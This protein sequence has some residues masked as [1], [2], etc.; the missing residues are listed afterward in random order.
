MDTSLL[1]YQATLHVIYN[2]PGAEI[3]HILNENQVLQE[4]IEIF[5]D[6]VE[7][8]KIFMVFSQK[9]R[10]VTLKSLILEKAYLETQD[11]KEF[12]NYAE[13]N[14]LPYFNEIRFL[15]SSSPQDLSY[16]IAIKTPESEANI[17]LASC[18]IKVTSATKCLGIFNKTKYEK[19]GHLHNNDV[20]DYIETYLLIK[21][22][23][24]PVLRLVSSYQLHELIGEK[25]TGRGIKTNSKKTHK[26]FEDNMGKA[27]LEIELLA[28]AT[29]NL[30][31][32]GQAQR[33]DTI[34][35][36][37]KVLGSLPPGK[38]HRFD[39]NNKKHMKLVQESADKFLVVIK[40][41][42][43]DML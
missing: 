33:Q 6:L 36:L 13:A 5:N 11:L 19:L 28:V 32:H 4:R 2:S 34:D 40:N 35:A 14:L 9:Y 10:T 15:Y 25:M 21:Q 43:K 41:Y 29:R 16:Y 17:I 39:R 8:Y 3:Q 24:D 26:Y 12:Y 31:S 18:Q 7:N 27:I 42:L 23:Q 22:F 37:D 38:Y 1:N 20:D 30:V